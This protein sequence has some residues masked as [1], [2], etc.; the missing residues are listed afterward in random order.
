MLL[1][2]IQFDLLDLSPKPQVIL[3]R[4]KI[5]RKKSTIELNRVNKILD[6][7]VLSGKNFVCG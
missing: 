7:R 4:W 1:D 5:V 3:D 6:F 2:H